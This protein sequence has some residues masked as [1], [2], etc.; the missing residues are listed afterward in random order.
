MQYSAG[1]SR[2]KVFPLK[3]S[4][5]LL[6]C[7]FSRN[8]WVRDSRFFC[9]CLFLLLIMPF[10]Y[11]LIKCPRCRL[12]FFYFLQHWVTNKKYWK[13]SGLL[14]LK[15]VKGSHGSINTVVSTSLPKRDGG[16]TWVLIYL[17]G[18]HENYFFI[19]FWMF[20]RLWKIK[21]Y[22][23][24]SVEKNVC[25]KPIQYITA[26]LK[27]ADGYLFDSDQN[28]F[29]HIRKYHENNESMYLKIYK[30]SLLRYSWT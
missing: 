16:K 18:I 13:H 1:V 4:S 24:V 14:H 8:Y 9:I 27:T 22:H 6:I 21:Q 5:H 3:L 26:H 2:E 20:V 11:S 7:V 15:R 12:L 30:C 29:I 28:T 17:I 23:P 25:K 10:R 19:C